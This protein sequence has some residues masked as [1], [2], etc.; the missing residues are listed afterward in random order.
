MYARTSGTTG[1]PKLFRSPADRAGLKRAPARHG[2]RAAPSF[3]AFRGRV[4]GIGGASREETLADGTPAGAATGLIYETMPRLIRA[5][6]VM[7]AEVF[8]IEDY[9]LQI[10]GDRPACAAVRAT[11]ASSPPPTPPPSCACCTRSNAGPDR[12]PGRDWR[13]VAAR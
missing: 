4:L 12:D 9:E 3:D 13:P 1:K 5:K 2:L 10:R 7:P 11:S 6:Y 8:A